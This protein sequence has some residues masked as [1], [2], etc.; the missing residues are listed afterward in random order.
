MKLLW[1][2][3]V[4]WSDSGEFGL[5]IPFFFWQRLWILEINWTPFFFCPSQINCCR[6]IH[7][8]SSV[9]RHPFF[10]CQ[11]KWLRDCVLCLVFLFWTFF[12]WLLWCICLV[13]SNFFSLWLNLNFISSFPCILQ[14]LVLFRAG[15]IGDAIDAIA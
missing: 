15:S 1:K 8:I 2:V 13:L 9:P 11:T 6:K 12:W 3:L 14:Q 10:S 5:W 7:W 4:I